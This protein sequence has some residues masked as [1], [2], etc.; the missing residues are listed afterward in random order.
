MPLSN[1]LLR[2]T[3][4]P[5]RLLDGT[6]LRSSNLP[7]IQYKDQGAE[8]VGHIPTLRIG[9]KYS[10]RQL[11]QLIAHI[12]QGSSSCMDFEHDLALQDISRIDSAPFRCSFR[13]PVET[14]EQ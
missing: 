10:K 8:L 2:L 11:A 5:L 9:Y 12:D 6:L 7:D 14:V 13:G 1:Y 3:R 4:K